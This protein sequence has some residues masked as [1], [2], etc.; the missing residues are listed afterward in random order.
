MKSVLVKEYFG[1]CVGFASSQAW[2]AGVSVGCQLKCAGIDDAEDRLRAVHL[3]PA[4][5]KLPYEMLRTGERHQ[6]NLARVLG[7]SNIAI[8]EFT[9]A[10]DRELAKRVAVGLPNIMWPTASLELSWRGATPM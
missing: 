1:G 2:Q 7:R 9:S 6:V 8:D 3:S 10:L 5:L 4:V